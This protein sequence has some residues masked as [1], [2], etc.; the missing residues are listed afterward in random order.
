VFGITETAQSTAGK[1]LFQQVAAMLLDKKNAGRYNQALMDFGAL[2]CLPKKPLCAQCVFKRTCYAALQDV[3]AEL[4]TKKIKAT[5]KLRFFN[6]FFITHNDSFL[7][8]YREQKDIWQGLY[9]L[10]L[11]ETH[12]AVTLQELLQSDEYKH[13]S[14][15]EMSFDNNVFEQTQNLT[16]RK[17]HF[18]IYTAKTS[19][20]TFKNLSKTYKTCKMADIKKI[21]FPKTLAY[22]LNIYHLRGK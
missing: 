1:K 8:S 7:I 17:I 13:L 20:K 10:P 4:P 3:V 9:E 11:I 19:A 2:I 6:Y 5:L 15:Q 16:H 22:F 18:K 12:N 14:L 21:S